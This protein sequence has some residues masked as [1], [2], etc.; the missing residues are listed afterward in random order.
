MHAID[1]HPNFHSMSKIRGKFWTKIGKLSTFKES[2]T[3]PHFLPENCARLGL[4]S[5]G[6]GWRFQKASCPLWPIMSHCHQWCW[7]FVCGHKNTVVE[8]MGVVLPQC[9]LQQSNCFHFPLSQSGFQII[10]NQTYQIA[11][12][13]YC[14]RMGNWAV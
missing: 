4:K 9:G 3:G 12:S 11:I 13:G 2:S 5:L 14:S 1:E 7:G 10:C 8:G 6:F